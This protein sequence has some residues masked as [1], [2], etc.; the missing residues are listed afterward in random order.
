MFGKNARRNVGVQILARQQRTMA[1][2][3]P[4]FEQPQL[5]HHLRVTMDHAGIVHHLGQ[6]NAGRMIHHFRNVICQQFGPGSFHMGRWNA[7]RQ[8]NANIHQAVFAG[9]L[10]IANAIQSDH[11]GNFMG[12]TNGRRHTAR[13]N[14]AVKFKRR[15]QRAF[16]VQMRVDKPGNKR[17]ARYINGFTRLILCADPD[18]RIAANGHIAFNELTG[19]QIKHT[20]AP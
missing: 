16:D 1:V 14:A 7:G 17:Q 3:V 15:N 20:P 8:L 2:L 19:D 18:D 10:E 6:T 5:V 9:G 4:P 13:T 12:V 11:I